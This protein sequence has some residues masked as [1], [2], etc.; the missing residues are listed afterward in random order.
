MLPRGPLFRVTI[1]SHGITEVSRGLQASKVRI[2]DLTGAW[3]HVDRVFHEQVAQQFR[4]DGAQGG[5]PWAPLAPRTQAERRRRGLGPSR[6]I[7]RRTGALLDS[8]T[9]MNS[10]AISVHTASSYRRGTGVEYY[11][12]HASTAP[13]T[14][15]PR[16]APFQPTTDQRSALFAPVRLHV[17]GRDPARRAADRARGLLQGPGGIR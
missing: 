4:S 11:G 9:K 3:P 13:R 10:D 12:Y 15:L 1:T 14:K 17:T 16:R 2:E 7:L 8:L 6:P 5:A